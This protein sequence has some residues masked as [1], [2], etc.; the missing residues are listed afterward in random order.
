MINT[1][2]LRIRGIGIGHLWG[3]ELASFELGQLLS[4]L[5][6][7]QMAPETIDNGVNQNDLGIFLI[8]SAGMECADLEWLENRAHGSAR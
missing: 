3:V 7:V 6:K 5:V 8:L 2:A 4:F 1:R